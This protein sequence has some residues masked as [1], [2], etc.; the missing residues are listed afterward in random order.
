[1][2]VLTKRALLACGLYEGLDFWKLPYY[3][4]F[5]ILYIIY[6]FGFEGPIEIDFYGLYK[7]YIGFVFH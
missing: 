7:D 3:T 2:G 6:W 4:I 5:H 1:M